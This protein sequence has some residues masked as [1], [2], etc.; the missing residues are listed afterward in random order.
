[1]N[2][3]PEGYLES[4]LEHV[5]TASR[6]DD[7]ARKTAVR[8]FNRLYYDVR[9]WNE[10]FISFL[11]T[12]PGFGGSSTPA[13]FKTFLGQLYEY[14]ESLAERYGSV[15]GD[16][17]T[18]L[19]ILS[20]RYSKDFGWLY[21]QN[22]LL[23]DQIRSLID[24]TYASETNVIAVAHGVC[25]FIWSV[26]SDP[27]WHEKNYQQI[28]DRITQYEQESKGEV[29]KIK[30]MADHVGIHLLDI[31]EYEAIL[32][33]EGSSNP[34]VMVVGEITMSQDNIH[35]QNV[36]GPVNVKARMDHVKQ[37]VTNASAVPNKG[38]KQLAALFEQLKQ[39]LDPVAQVQPEDAQ[40]VLQAAEMVSAEVSKQKPS[41]SFLN[42]TAEGLKEAAKA[43]GAVAPTV[44]DVAIKIA[45]SV[46]KLLP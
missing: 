10:A 6:R 31:A 7:A 2:R 39:A 21:E 35:I 46:S 15:K 25:Q 41:K 33:N 37:V 11:R 17:C 14:R 32:N 5:A 34:E 40:R 29:S 26:E 24:N 18:C 23:Y 3:V 36:V 38:K 1:M 44:L 20:A 42:I 45:T 28:V 9:K 13:K 8:W 27:N 22:Q 43:V 4:I 30:L 12:Y 16:L 19:K